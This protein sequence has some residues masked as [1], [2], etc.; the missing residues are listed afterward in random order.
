MDGCVPE[1][2]ACV[3][4]LFTFGGG[5]LVGYSSGLREGLRKAQ[6]IWGRND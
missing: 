3:S 6:E 1:W 2:I 4:M 5:W